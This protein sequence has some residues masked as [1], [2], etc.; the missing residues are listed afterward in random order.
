MTRRHGASSFVGR[1]EQLDRLE[2][3][4][5]SAKQG[6]PTTVLI[7]GD[8]GVG[9]TRL[10]TEFT[11][12]A[13]D[14]DA[15]VLEGGCLELAEQGLPYAA[16]SEALR[17]LSEDVGG[18]ELRRLAG[19][20]ARHLARLIPS[21]QD[22][23]PAT[24]TST[25]LG[26]DSQLRLFEAL[27]GLLRQLTA[28]HPVVLVLEDVHWADASTRDLLV[29]LAHNLR[30]VPL[31]LL[32]SYRTDE[33]HRQHPLRHTLTQLARHERVER[34]ELPPL[35]RD[36][37]VVLLEA[38]L[39]HPPGPELIG[40]V[41]ERSQGNPFFAEELL[42]AGGDP[43]ELPD[44]LRDILLT[45]IDRLPDETVEALRVVAAAGG[46]TS[47]ELVA[48][49]GGCDAAELEAVMRT[50][51][52]HGVL[53]ADAA[54]GS[55][56]FRHALLSEAVY[57]TLLPGEVG[58]LH[59]RLAEAI[60]EDPA[61]A[62][63]AP[64]AERAHHWHRA[65]D[66]P[67]SLTAS[68]E[69]AREAEAAAGLAEAR[70]HVERVLEL[71]EL[72]DDAADR[73]G[74]THTQLLGW[75]AELC[76]LTGIPDHAIALQQ[77][78]LAEQTHADPA[79]R[80]LLY[81]QLAGFRHAAGDF[82][83]ADTASETA[84]ELLPPDAA[85]DQR[86]WVLSTRSRV[87]SVTFRYDD[88][89]HYAEQA[90]AAAR[91]AD[92]REMEGIVLGTLG[93]NL[94]HRGEERGYELLSEARQVAEELGD[95][96]TILRTYQN[97]AFALRLHGRFDASIELAF[98]GLERAREMGNELLVGYLTHTVAFAALRVGKWELANEM[99][100][101]L[102]LE[103]GPAVVGQNHLVRATLLANRGQT[104]AAR[105]ALD[106]SL[107]F[108]GRQGEPG[109]ARTLIARLATALVEHDDD[110]IE[111][112]LDQRPKIA[113]RPY[114]P[115]EQGELELRALLLRAL[116]DHPRRD[117]DR[118]DLTDEVLEE[119]RRFAEHHPADMGLVPAWLALA[120]AEYAR[121]TG[122]DDAVERWPAAVERCDGFGLAHETA[123]A[124]FRL[125]EALLAQDRRTE[126]TPP[127][128]AAAD[129]AR[130]LGAAP[131]E[132]D[133]TDL[134]RRARIDL[135]D[136]RPA[137]D[138]GDGL[139]LTPRETEVLAL[140]ADGRSNPEIA[141]Q[142]FISRKTASVHVSNILRKLEV[143]SRG[144]AAALAHRND[145]TR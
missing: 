45:T 103:T 112:V 117:D 59:R 140:L 43:A 64:A 30:D 82:A 24:S 13:R 7:G 84:V 100:R 58:R 62:S 14:Q 94:A 120:E 125:A 54:G 89:D 105:H 9:K 65:Q 15:L 50:A 8:A 56:T 42:A 86:A 113:D 23:E 61:L 142:L 137:D 110:A 73:T 46:P 17:D 3:A 71:W 111:Q 34:V 143:D 134:A 95:T 97:A 37:L 101:T 138:S 66:Q 92:D 126:A 38:Q 124:R 63:H 44:L 21:L 2:R 25:G 77:R 91:E 4:L 40:P 39:G 48:R 5:R 93:T 128:R 114:T 102:P 144:E 141:E 108:G 106:A 68:I 136:N 80:A 36:E 75:A 29:F 98:E 76:H 26:Q 135:G 130:D 20:G 47:H 87:L 60:E 133:V 41:Y 81:C 74:M 90:L 70:T 85:P 129:V 139:G 31:M 104:Q 99:L 131:L 1:A 69:A 121:A 78:A 127:L 28:V 10:I 53:D 109:W 35:D 27:L 145:L 83:G 51:V 33:L 123:Y 57:A 6:T 116:A 11:A 132:G 12:R 122:H 52:Q 18:L 107:R 32:A 22:D 16:V 67:R 119:S 72:V 19:S 118:G 55:Y 88:S 49:V 115:A 96:E 79:T